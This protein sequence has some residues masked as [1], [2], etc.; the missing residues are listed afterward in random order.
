MYNNII[1]F[2]ISWS[3]WLRCTLALLCR[4]FTSSLLDNFSVR[5]LKKSM[6]H[7]VSS[8]IMFLLQ[9]IDMYHLEFMFVDTFYL[10]NN[11]ELKY[12]Y[13]VHFQFTSNLHF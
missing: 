10:F 1:I 6:D 8:N 11:Y 12:Y 7:H 13:M 5:I 4:I 3:M 2:V 9:V